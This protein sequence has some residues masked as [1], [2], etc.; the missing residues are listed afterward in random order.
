MVSG[1]NSSFDGEPHAGAPLAE[2]NS[3]VSVTMVHDE[4]IADD[5]YGTSHEGPPSHQSDEDIAYGH[6]TAAEP[7]PPVAAVLPPEVLSTL[8]K[9]RRTYREW[10]MLLVGLEPLF[11]LVRGRRG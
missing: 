10:F 3:S 9:E 4:T 2:A 7:A 1:P 5:G 6:L 11:E 8:G